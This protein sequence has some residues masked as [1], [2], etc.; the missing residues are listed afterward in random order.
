MAGTD[1]SRDVAL[2]PSGS[3]PARYETSWRRVGWSLLVAAGW[4]AAAI[5]V[6]MIYILALPER[7]DD[8]S[9]L[10]DRTGA[11]LFA[12][13]L[14][15]VVLVVASPIVV[16]LSWAVHRHVWSPLLT[17]TIAAAMSMV[18]TCC[19]TLVGLSAGGMS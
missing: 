8:L 11:L 1:D 13:I 14:V 2:F 15:P 3:A 12:L 4:Y 7:S 10:F 9:T 19:L 17:G 16:L 18:V 6:F 5:T